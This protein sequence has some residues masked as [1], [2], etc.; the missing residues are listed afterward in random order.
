MLRCSRGWRDGEEG[1]F[2][3]LCVAD[4]AGDVVVLQQGIGEY[5]GRGEA[6]RCSDGCKVAAEETGILQLGNG[7]RA[8]RDLLEVIVQ[9]RHDGHWRG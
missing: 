1:A 4:Q 7:R 5:L 6:R 3:C 2:V 9:Q 8:E